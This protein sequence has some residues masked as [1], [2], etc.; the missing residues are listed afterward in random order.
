MRAVEES[1]ARSSEPEIRPE[2]RQKGRE[3]QK[4]SK[5]RGRGA[6]GQGRA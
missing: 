2:K 5:V 3:K 1:K 6:E 4:E